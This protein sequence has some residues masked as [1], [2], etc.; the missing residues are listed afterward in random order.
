MIFDENHSF[1][2]KHPTVR[3]WLGYTKNRKITK[4]L[5]NLLTLPE[6]IGKHDKSVM[7][8]LE[9]VRPEPE[10]AITPIPSPNRMVPG[11]YLTP[12][13]QNVK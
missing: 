1:C 10:I 3:A 6:L 5:Q 4:T 7:G 11:T 12:F 13:H 8:N 2:E 9:V